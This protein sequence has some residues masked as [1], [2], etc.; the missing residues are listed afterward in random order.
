MSATTSTLPPAPSAEPAVEPW[1]I[2]VIVAAY[3]L[4]HRS[5]PEPDATAVFE[6]ARLGLID[7]HWSLTEQGEEALRQHGWL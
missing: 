2:E 4:A 6:A 1:P 5:G 3:W 7:G